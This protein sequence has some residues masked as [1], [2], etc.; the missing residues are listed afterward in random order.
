MAAAMLL[1][2]WSAGVLAN[3]TIRISTG[4]SLLHADSIDVYE[5]AHAA[6]AKMYETFDVKYY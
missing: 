5:K 6:T 2:S 1:I 3:H 4:T